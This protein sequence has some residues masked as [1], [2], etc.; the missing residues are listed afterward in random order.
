MGCAVTGI[1]DNNIHQK[2]TKKTSNYSHR[3]QIYLNITSTYPEHFNPIFFLKKRIVMSYSEILCLKREVVSHGQKQK[4]KK[5]KEKRKNKPNP[6]FCPFMVC[7]V[8][9]H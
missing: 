9:G 3:P 2:L 1:P 6:F 8:T 4:G 7:D 5:K